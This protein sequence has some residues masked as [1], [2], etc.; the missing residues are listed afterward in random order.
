MFL[1]T[2][3][4]GRPGTQSSE[5]RSFSLLGYA[6]R[7]LNTTCNRKTTKPCCK[8]LLNSCHLNA[9]LFSSSAKSKVKVIWMPP[10]SLESRQ[11]QSTT[12]LSK[13]HVR[14]LLISKSTILPWSRQ[15]FVIFSTKY[16]LTSIWYLSAISLSK[17]EKNETGRSSSSDAPLYR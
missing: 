4:R 14:S 17:K 2:F 8:R 1:S 7:K 11:G 6:T 13:E 9:G 16:H 3:W 15:Y 10:H 12:I 5:N